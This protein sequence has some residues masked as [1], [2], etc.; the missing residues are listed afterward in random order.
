MKKDILVWKTTETVTILA[1]GR[2]GTYRIIWHRTDG[3]EEEFDVTPA[4]DEA[5]EEAVARDLRDRLGP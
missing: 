2:E 5:V 3:N 4:A 1:S